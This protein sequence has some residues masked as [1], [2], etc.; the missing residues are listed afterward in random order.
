MEMIP[1]I[2][3]LPNVHLDP[4]IP[5]EY[6]GILYHGCFVNPECS[7]KKESNGWLE[8][9]TFCVV[10]RYPLGREKLKAQRPILWRHL[11]WQG[12]M[13]ALEL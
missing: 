4:A 3:D 7:L 8:S 2:I 10:D 12:S 13:I 9:F 5:V 1:A 6:Y 11:S